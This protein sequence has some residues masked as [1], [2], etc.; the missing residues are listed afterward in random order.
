MNEDLEDLDY[1]PEQVQLTE[2]RDRHESTY[3]T[4]RPRNLFPYHSE[5]EQPGE[6][7]SGHIGVPRLQRRNA[8]RRKHGY[9]KSYIPR[10]QQKRQK[11]SASPSYPKSPS[12]VKTD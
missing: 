5:K 9:H 3:A 6:V 12:N 1:S 4:L 8:I 11:A 2:H 7:E 10:R